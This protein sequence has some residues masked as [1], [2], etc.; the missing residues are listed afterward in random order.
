M[1]PPGALH[2][3][4]RLAVAGV[5]PCAD[6]FL[7]FVE[8]I[9][10][11]DRNGIRLHD[12]TRSNSALVESKRPC[13]SKEQAVMAT[14]PT[15]ESAARPELAAALR[16]ALLDKQILQAHLLTQVNRTIR[17]LHSA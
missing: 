2:A 17:A 16:F 9:R 7:R 14:A 6:S 15:Q 13:L 3:V 5:C 4:V 12:A 8:S 10:Q 1:V 11:F